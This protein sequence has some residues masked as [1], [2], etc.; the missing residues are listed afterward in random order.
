MSNGQTSLTSALDRYLSEIEDP[1]IEFAV[2]QQRPETLEETDAS[3][4]EMESYAAVPD[5]GMEAEVS[6]TAEEDLDV[7]AT[8][9]MSLHN[10]APTFPHYWT[11][12]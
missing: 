10:R 5:K 7:R 12:F 8:C 11:L 1:K 6:S 9:V 2:R 3:T 4:L